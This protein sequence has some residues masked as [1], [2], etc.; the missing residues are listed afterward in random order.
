MLQRIDFASEWIEFQRIRSLS[1]LPGV[2]AQSA[3]TD[4]V[5]QL[6]NFLSDEHTLRVPFCIWNPVLHWSSPGIVCPPV[7]QCTLA[8]RH[9][10]THSRKEKS[11]MSDTDSWL[12]HGM[13]SQKHQLL[14]IGVQHWHSRHETSEMVSVQVLQDCYVDIK[15]AIG[16]AT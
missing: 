11:F 14:N 16:N 8:P 9:I 15:A 5:A 10:H 6:A 2:E 4:V 3:V 12:Q 7:L 13:R 1:P